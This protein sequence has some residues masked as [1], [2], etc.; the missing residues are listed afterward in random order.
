MQACFFY[1]PL[2]LWNVWEG[3][4]MTLLVKDV[5]GPFV[6]SGWHDTIRPKLVNY[7]M[8]FKH[9]HTIYAYRYILCE[10]LN[11]TNVLLQMFFINWLLNGKFI[12]YGFRFVD[13]QES[14]SEV[15]PR[16]TKCKYHRY[17]PTG[18]VENHDFLCVLALNILNEKLFLIIWFWFVFLIVV[19][20]ISVVYRL[21]IV[22]SLK[23]RAY[24][25]MTQTRCSNVEEM[26]DIVDGINYGSFF[27]L[28]LIGR[29]TN[30]M[31]YNDILDSVHTTV[32]REKPMRKANKIIVV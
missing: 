3:G 27:V 23:L 25:L 12:S 8:S 26:E 19:S 11:L 2:Y 17:G 5:S 28:Y 18:T 6:P 16:T 1:A 13:N 7:V 32:I 20:V 4:R 15:F 10:A 9:Y 24:L 21:L 22:F 29:N 30:P 31:V 14:L